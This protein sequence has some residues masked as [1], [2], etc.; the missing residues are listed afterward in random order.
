MTNIAHTITVTTLADGGRDYD[1]T[2][3]TT[4]PA[5][6][7]CEIRLRTLRLRSD[8]MTA[9]TDGRPDGTYHLGLFGFNGLCLTDEAG[10]MLP[11]VDPAGTEPNACHWCSI[12][13]LEHGIQWADQASNHEWEQPSQEQIK[14]RMLAR[15]A[16]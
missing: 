6:E 10:H 13:K 3:P 11:D 5:G 16:A 1:W 2:H 12:G 15:R 9:L 4:C 14:T 8:D 7:A